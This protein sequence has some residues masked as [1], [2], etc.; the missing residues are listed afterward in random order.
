MIYFIL[1]RIFSCLLDLFAI[2]WRSDH[3]KDL[4]ILLLRQQL[5][6]LQRKRPCPPRISRWEKLALAVLVAKLTAVGGSARNRLGQIV[7]VFKPETLLKWHR[8]LVRRKWTFTNQRTG[9][10]PPIPADLEARILHLAKE[11]PRWGYSKL[12]GELRKLGYDLGRTTVQDVLK[13]HRVPPTPVRAKQASSWRTFLRHYQDQILACDFF[14]VET[15]WLKTIYVLFFLELGTRRVHIAGCT[16]EPTAGWVAQQ[17]RQLTWTI[18]DERLPLRFLMHDRDAK[19]PG[20]FDTVI[21][22][23]GIE[24]IRTPCRAPK[25]NAFAERWVRSVREECLDHLLIFGEAHLRRVLGE[26]VA[27]YNHA[28]PHQGIDQQCPVRRLWPSGSGPIQRRDVLGGIIH[29]YYR[30][31]A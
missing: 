9:G 20:A 16:G 31:A 22:A 14:T 12:H 25:A 29:D 6:I 4:E 3:E 15:V 17:A 10:R 13:R 2:M 11:N 8:E 24:I 5:R 1:A 21:A 18:Q 7:L 30:A 27:Y 23:E 19:F 28:R 26:Y